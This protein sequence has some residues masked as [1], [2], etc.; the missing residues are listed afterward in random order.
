MSS[1]FSSIEVA[2]LIW[3]DG[4]PYCAASNRVYCS[5]VDDVNKAERVFIQG[6]NLPSRWQRLKEQSSFIIAETQFGAGLNFLI[7]WSY[8]LQHAPKTARLHYIS[9]ENH[10]LTQDD[11]IRVLSLWPDFKPQSLLLQENYPILTPGFHQFS[12]EEG[13]IT[14]TLMLGEAFTCFNEL[15]LCGDAILEKKLR[16]HFVDAWYFNELTHLIKNEGLMKSVALL[17]GEGATLTS[18]MAMDAVKN[19]LQQAGFSVQ[20]SHAIFEQCTRRQRRNTP[21]HV[22]APLPVKNKRAIVLGAGLGGCFSAYSLATRGWDVLLIEGNPDVG[23]GASGVPRAVLYPKLSAFCSPLT[24]FMLSAYLYAHRFYAK[25]LKT[26]P[27]GELGGI[28]QMAFNEKE[29]ISQNSMREWLKAYP[30]LGKLVNKDEATQ[31]AGVKLHTSGLYLPLSGWLDCKAIC[32]FLS[33]QKGI[34]FVPDFFVD[35]LE[36][37]EGLWS[38]NGKYQSEVVIIANGFQANLFKQTSHLPL[39]AMAGQL[40]MITGNADSNCLKIPLCGEGHILPAWKNQHIL[41]ATYHQSLHTG[42]NDDQK[43]LT[44]L[45]TLTTEPVFSHQVIGNWQ[46]VRGATPD[47]LP[48]VGPVPDAAAFLKTFSP[49]ATD[50][51]RWLPYSGNY[52]PGL[53]VCAGFGSRGLTTAP[54]CAEWLASVINNEPDFLPRRLEQALSPSRFLVKRIVK[55]S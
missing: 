5:G 25:L 24:T 3:R 16:A 22:N 19:D 14:L 45:A 43:N 30:V 38:L 42:D 54:L 27:V 9:C 21:W 51:R 41:G 10:P 15:V 34:T 46:G 13:R 4:L 11:L 48:L 23:M 39:K 49:L 12:F 2:Q 44:K 28:L 53:Y 18:T 26:H 33:Q 1:P 40:T 37:K 6:N 17:S 20:K 55:G 7:S 52:Y 8:W 50:S 29:T 35:E 32:D 47:Y 36:Y 31:L